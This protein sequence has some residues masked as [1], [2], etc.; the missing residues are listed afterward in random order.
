MGKVGF[1]VPERLVRSV[2]LP[3]NGLEPARSAPGC[4]RS[5]A[6]AG[7]EA[8]AC[9]RCRSARSK[10]VDR[11]TA[12]R[13]HGRSPGAS[14]PRLAAGHGLRAVVRRSARRLHG[15]LRALR[16]VG[17][18]TAFHSRSGGRAAC[19]GDWRGSGFPQYPQEPVYACSGGLGRVCVR[20][21]TCAGHAK[22]GGKRN[23]RARCSR[24]LPRSPIDGRTTG[25]V[26]F[27][28]PAAPPGRRAGGCRVV[29]T[30]R[31]RRAVPRR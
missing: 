6:A 24:F 31:L 9:R 19:R 21:S 18:G 30:S 13:C 16:A 8:A 7:L 2:R 29:F 20:T 27:A 25:L 10:V 28:T 17:N 26:Y 15:L 14:A 3:A 12:E 22:P 4:A 5:A 1:S 23:V 11:S